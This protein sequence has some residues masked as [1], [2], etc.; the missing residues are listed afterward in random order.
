MSCVIKTFT[1]EIFNKILK[2]VAKVVSIV[3]LLEKYRRASSVLQLRASQNMNSSLP[4]DS[5][6][7]AFKL[8]KNC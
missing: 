5:R 8:L 6:P 1:D 3:G 2:A 7:K 4:M